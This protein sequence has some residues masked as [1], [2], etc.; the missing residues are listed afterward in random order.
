MANDAISCILAGCSVS[1]RHASSSLNL[2][3]LVV[4]FGDGH[5]IA[6][7][8]L[9]E[10]G[11]VLESVEILDVATNEWK[12]VVPQTNADFPDKRTAPGA[13]VHDNT[14]FVFGGCADDGGGA[15]VRSG[16]SL[17]LNEDGTELSLSLP[18]RLNLSWLT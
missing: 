6:I 11:K 10:N 15:P 3:F 4:A 12:Y 5:I 18:R 17:K 8:G 14:I 7:G 13:V 16:F 9:D 2:L 1:L